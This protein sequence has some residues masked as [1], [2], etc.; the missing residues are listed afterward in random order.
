MIGSQVG[1]DGE[2]CF[3]LLRFWSV[4]RSCGC[5]LVLS[6]FV[7]SWNWLKREAFRFEGEVNWIKWRR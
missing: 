7:A 2:C 3:V 1:G 5:G 4:G 6:R